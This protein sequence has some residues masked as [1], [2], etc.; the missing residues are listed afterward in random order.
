[1]GGYQKSRTEG[2]VLVPNPRIWYLGYQ[3]TPF[4]R[5][6]LVPT[7]AKVRTSLQQNA[8]SAQ[9]RGLSGRTPFILRGPL[10]LKNPLIPARRRAALP[11]QSSLR[12]EQNW[13]LVLT[14]C[15]L[16]SAKQGSCAHRVH[17]PVSKIGLW[18]S[19]GHYFLAVMESF[20]G[21]VMAIGHTLLGGKSFFNFYSCD[22]PLLSIAQADWKS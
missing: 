8:T 2:H 3:E 10:T 11:Y 16:R 12:G 9:N 17:S 1:M 7:P 13:G 14:G 22:Y 5:T 20:P 15:I 18:H 4:Q 6:F 19:R 21:P